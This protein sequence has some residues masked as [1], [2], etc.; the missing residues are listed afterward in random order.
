MRFKGGCEVRGKSMKKITIVIFT[1]LVSSYSMAY[2]PD[3]AKTNQAHE[4][5]ECAVFYMYG[6]EGVK[7]NGDISA[8]NQLM[9][10]AQRAV[11]LSTML[12]NQE[13]TEARMEM[14]FDEQSELINNDFS[15][16][17]L[18][19]VK[20]KDICKLAVGTPEERYKYYL[21]K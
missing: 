7:R 4:L 11:E 8:S 19:L 1:L 18:L 15:N 20:Y 17:S 2:E 10:S 5:C 13:V 9:A 14:A 16:I 6:A 3:R 21:M 12:S